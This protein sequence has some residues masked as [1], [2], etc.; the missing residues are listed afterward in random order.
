[1]PAASG[2]RRR[3]WIAAGVVAALLA[4]GATNA[5]QLPGGTPGPQ[6]GEPPAAVLPDE[7]EA[8][9]R[10]RASPTQENA[11]ALA[12]VRA[13]YGSVLLDLARQKKDALALEMALEHAE[14]A[15]QLDP[16]QG[17][18]WLLL[19]LAYGENATNSAS[20]AMAEDAAGRACRLQPDNPRFRLCLG[21]ILFRQAFYAAA[22]DEFEKAL[23]KNP[24]LAEPQLAAMMTLA[25]LL[26]DLAPRGEAFLN[27]LAKARPL[28][29]PLLLAKAVL[30]NRQAMAASLAALEAPLSAT[31]LALLAHSQT[32]DAL[33]R[34]DLKA[35]AESPQAKP[36][37]REFAQAL[38]KHWSALPTS[39]P[40]PGKARPDTPK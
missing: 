10:Y 3:A 36:A 14:S 32:K 15:T 19:A 7:A 35:V 6:E 13:K 31:H 25:Y 9:A 16:Q 34:A 21:Q 40:A 28:S 30:A 38:L 26:D 4:A 11:Q 18:Y 27:G 12:R 5:G 33:A 22:L 29:P 1:M 2:E 20:L 17:A 39:R 23:A 8:M 24:A 37:E